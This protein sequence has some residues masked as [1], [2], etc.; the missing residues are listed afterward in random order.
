[1]IVVEIA[2]AAMI[3]ARPLIQTWIGS[4]EF[5]SLADEARV[6]GKRAPQHVDAALA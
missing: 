6:R 4:D 5:V 1:M 3:Y 2:I